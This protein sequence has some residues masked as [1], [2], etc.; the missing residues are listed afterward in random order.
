MSFNSPFSDTAAN[1]GLL[2]LPSSLLSGT[3]SVWECHSAFTFPT[4]TI[5]SSPASM[6]WFCI[7]SSVISAS[8]VF[9]LTSSFLPSSSGSAGSVTTN[10]AKATSS[11]IG[12][13]GGVVGGNNPPSIA[14]WPMPC[15]YLVGSFGS[16]SYLVALLAVCRALV[17]TSSACSA[18]DNGSSQAPCAPCGGISET[19]T[20]SYEMSPKSAIAV[21]TPSSA[22]A[23]DANSRA[24]LTKSS[25]LPVT[26]CCGFPGVCSFHP[27]D[28][29]LRNCG[30]HSTSVV[31]T[32][33]KFGMPPTR[34]FSLSFS[35]SCSM[36]SEDK[37]LQ[38]AVA[39]ASASSS[40]S[41]GGPIKLYQAFRPPLGAL[42]TAESTSGIRETCKRS[43]SK[44]AI[45]ASV[46]ANA[47]AEN[48]SSGKVDGNGTSAFTTPTILVAFFFF[49]SVSVSIWCLAFLAF[50]KAFENAH[51]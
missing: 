45:S 27:A 4:C 11:L 33:A 5:V 10:Q 44:L 32:E 40:V 14:K 35:D 39:A 28:D 49:F 46:T 7:F 41:A 48:F 3:S 42:A 37:A 21:L 2:L 16:G 24:A 18:N 8:R 6:R 30:L 34:R 20:L 17:S 51:Q 50:T 23:S 38:M 19:R 22:R 9:S 36:V 13:G 12:M 29:R 15:S 47:F 43:L 31:F 25:M 1:E 26:F